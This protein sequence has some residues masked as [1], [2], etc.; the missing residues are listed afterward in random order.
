MAS[1][2][3]FGSGII[4]VFLFTGSPDRVSPLSRPGTRPGIRPVI[5]D[6]QLEGLAIRRGFLLPFGHR[7]SLLG[8]PI[9]AEELGPPHGRLTGPTAGPRRGYRVPHAR[10]ATGVGALYTPGT[11]VLIPDRAPLPGRRLPLH[12]GQSLHPATTSHPAGLSLHEA[13]TRVQAIHPS[14]LPLACGRPDGTGALRLSPELRTPPTKSR[15]THVGVGTGHRARTWNYTLNAHQS[16]L[17]SSVVHSMS[18]TSRR[19]GGSRRRAF[20]AIQGSRHH[21]RDARRG[22][23]A[24]LTRQVRGARQH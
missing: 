5:R 21:A 2:L 1:S 7:H 3:S 9:P 11:T 17:Q 4:V 16:I 10:A 24:G 14:G 18:A 23:R 22:I 6:D 8:H 20:R 12:S 19:R 15:T 13:S